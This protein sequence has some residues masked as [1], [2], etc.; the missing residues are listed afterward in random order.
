MDWS[1]AT[2][3]WVA[4]GVLIAAELATGTFYLLMLALGAAAG[5]L[6]GYAGFG[7][8][9]QVVVAAVVA[10]GATAA[11]S[12][13]QSARSRLAP[14]EGSNPD[15]NLDIG[16]RVQIVSWASD[17]T[18]SVRYRGATWSARFAGTGMPAPGEHVI[19]AVHGSQLQV[20]PSA[21]L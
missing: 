15:V 7:I 12:V 1:T 5:A 13:R 18:A 14:S 6:A 2:W 8:A 16:Q 19:V 21:A 9:W 10:G 20:R 4:S 3:W 11:W 17:G